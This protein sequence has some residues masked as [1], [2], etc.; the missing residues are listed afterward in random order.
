LGFV[1]EN[2][3]YNYNHL[4]KF[5][6]LEESINDGMLPIGKNDFGDYIMLGISNENEG[7]IYFR[8]HDRKKDT[9]S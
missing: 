7:K 5:D 8:Y 9:S 3:Y 2:K 4:E 6:I 1:S